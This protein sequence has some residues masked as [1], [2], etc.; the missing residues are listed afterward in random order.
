MFHQ[1]LSPVG[2]SLLL[3]FLVAALPIIVVLL[4]L[5]WAR[6]PAWQASLAGLIVGLIVAI[7]VW[8]FPV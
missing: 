7:F 2:N 6:R 4:L 8:Q 3:S 5:G 1:L